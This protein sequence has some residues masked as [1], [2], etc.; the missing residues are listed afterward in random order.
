MLDLGVCAID[1]SG[2]DLVGPE[3]P[4][5]RD[6]ENR[7][8]RSVNV[9][10]QVKDI[11][12]DLR[13]QR[14][15]RIEQRKNKVLT[16]KD[17]HMTKKLSEYEA[18]MD[19]ITIPEDEILAL[20]NVLAHDGRKRLEKMKALL[21][22]DSVENT[23]IST[24]FGYARKRGDESRALTS[25]RR[26]TKLERFQQRVL[27]MEPEPL[28]R[29]KALYNVARSVSL[30]PTVRQQ[31]QPVRH[32]PN[33]LIRPHTK[34]EVLGRQ[35]QKHGDQVPLRKVTFYVMGK[36]T[37]A[38]PNPEKMNLPKW[39]QDILD[40][41]GYT[42][43]NVINWIKAMRARNANQAMEIMEQ[44]GSVWPKFLIQS[45]LYSSTPR[46]Q[47]ELVKIF[48][49]V[50][51]IWETF[52]QEG[53]VRAIIRMT[54]LSAK[55]LPQGL[56]RLAKMLA[57]TEFDG[58]KPAMRVF[59][60]VLAVTADA[61]SSKQHQNYTTVH[62]LRNY[63]DDSLITILDRMAEK[64]IHIKIQTLRKVAAAKLAEDSE[65]AIT[66]LRLGKPKKYV[67]LIEDMKG[68]EEDLALAYEVAKA[69]RQLSSLEKEFLK[70]HLLGRVNS[71]EMI[72]RLN[73]I[74][75]WRVSTQETFSTWLEFLERRRQLGPAPREAW[76]SVLQMCHDEWTFPTPFWEEAFEL[77]EEDG[78]LPN[79]ALLCLVLK[80]IKGG[81]V[82]DRVLETATTTH[83]QRMNDQ[84]WQ[85]YLS[86]LAITD[87]PRALEIFLNAL[88]TDEASGT[89][90]TLNIMYWNILLHGLSRETRRTNDLVWTTRA[91]ELLDE[92]ERLMILPTHQTLHAI[93]KLGSWA[94]DKIQIKGMPAW[95]AAIE[96]W[97]GFVIKPHDFGY[98]FYLP[99]IAR[100]MPSQPCWRVFIRLCGNY[101]E[102]AEVFDATWAMLR[103]GVQPDHETMLDID[104]FMQ[105]SGD[106]ERTLAVREM[107]REWLGRYP[108][109]R[110]VA[111]HYRRWLRAEVRAIL[112]PQ[113]ERLRLTGPNAP[114]VRLI[115]APS[116]KYNVRDVLPGVEPQH[117]T[118]V[119][120]WERREKAKPWFEM[121]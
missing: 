120:Q 16:S 67:D 47:A 94:G 19:K 1:L 90:D 48:D 82:L 56:P 7:N 39:A 102:Y 61:Y 93:C 30:R 115:E 111:W 9:A 14:R 70:G 52:D 18:P 23:K 107:F 64:D 57:V 37:G 41:R 45:L 74:Q 22:G 116:K 84:I 73:T 31:V 66:I 4:P 112:G 55:K 21:G 49:A 118:V 27:G 63:I 114:V 60:E 58:S 44:D 34:L 8:N 65:A 32:Q 6:P 85:A 119:E 26:P 103:F 53:K 104:V 78:V 24:A 38:L 11:L 3:R 51:S 87:T 77:M 89:M 69:E 33:K 97:H 17:S 71:K 121:D 83:K 92:M 109:P 98:N 110:E 105:L 76:I 99:K 75:N 54:E 91:F 72:K 113:E 10:A 80:G 68:Q 46:S 50:Q 42:A 43:Q 86:R 28:S 40:A 88:T 15:L 36:H 79:T 29:F 35:V 101:G 25:H 117:E 62:Q 96:T 5:V 106:E 81:E 13:E 2:A 59:N 95:K 100:L 12:C 20:Q 108:T